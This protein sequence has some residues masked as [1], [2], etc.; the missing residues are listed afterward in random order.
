MWRRL[1]APV[2]GGVVVLCSLAIG[3]SAGASSGS[4]RAATASHPNALLRAMTP[5]QRAAVSPHLAF[6]RPGA[7]FHASASSGFTGDVA[8]CPWLDTT[9]SVNQRVSMLMGR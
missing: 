4:D 2:V 6:A 3:A 1:R 5:A 9:L 8:S 7:T